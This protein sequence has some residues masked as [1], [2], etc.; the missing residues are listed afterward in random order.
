[1][2]QNFT[3]ENRALESTI[4]QR[5]LFPNTSAP[6]QQK[7]LEGLLSQMPQNNNMICLDAACGIGNNTETLLR[8]FSEVRAFDKSGKAVGFAIE[9]HNNQNKNIVSFKLG[10]LNMIPFKEESFDCVVCTEALEHVN[11]HEQVIREIYRVTK[12]GGHVVLSFQN[13]FNLSALIKYISEKVTKKNWD[14]W[15][16]HGHEEGYESYLMYFQIKRSTKLA[17]FTCVDEFGADYINAWL[18]WLPIFYRNYKI[19]DRYPMFFLGKLPIL[20]Y[21]G[22][23]YF[24]LLKKHD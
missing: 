2:G 13:H 9:R 14:A 20:K 5:E 15:G 19:L 1:M 6:W 24:L 23:D 18:A 16:T 7:A 10:E 12:P 8:Y 17:G 22:M 11:D 4:R 3:S 21:I